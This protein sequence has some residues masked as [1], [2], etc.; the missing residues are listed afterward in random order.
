MTEDN[1]NK[2]D[3]ITLTA[4]P[5]P[6]PQTVKFLLNKRSIKLLPIKPNPPVTIILCII[7]FTSI[8]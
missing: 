6:N 3:D 4:L 1:K 7:F 8:N 2:H 5:P